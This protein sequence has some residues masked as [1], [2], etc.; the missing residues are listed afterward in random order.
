MN[1]VKFNCLPSQS[2]S[3]LADDLC[4]YYIQTLNLVEPHPRVKPASILCTHILSHSFS[5]HTLELL[6]IGI[7]NVSDC[8]VLCC[9]SCN[10]RCQVFGSSPG[11]YPLTA[12]QNPPPSKI[13]QG[14]AN[15]SLARKSRQADSLSLRVTV[16]DEYF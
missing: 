15:C 16:T 13:Y 7:I 8:T 9:G 6:S 4:F 12:S 10:R 11:F 1:V 2:L 3:F 14:T 5:Y